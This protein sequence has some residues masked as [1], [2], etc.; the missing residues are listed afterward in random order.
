[1]VV[2]DPCTCECHVIALDLSQKAKEGM[3]VMLLAVMDTLTGIFKL[4]FLNSEAHSMLKSD[5]IIISNLI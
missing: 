1:M 3:D 2:H 5:I 4:H